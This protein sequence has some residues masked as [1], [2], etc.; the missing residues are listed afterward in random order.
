MNQ[1]SEKEFSV[2]LMVPQGK[3]KLFFTT[4]HDIQIITDGYPI[5]QQENPYLKAFLLFYKKNHFYKIKLK[6]KFGINN[7]SNCFIKKF[8]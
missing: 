8:I 6:F 4:L 1:I 2:K 3:H 7:K 5:E